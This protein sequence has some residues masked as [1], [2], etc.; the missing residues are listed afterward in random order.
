MCLGKCEPVP[1]PFIAD[2]LDGWSTVNYYLLA[3]GDRILM[4]AAQDFISFLSYHVTLLASEKSV[5]NQKPLVFLTHI[6]T[7]LCLCSLDL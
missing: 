1:G 2:V 5:V 7:M 4:Q 6:L 3:S